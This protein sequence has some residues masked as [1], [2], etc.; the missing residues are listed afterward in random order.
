MQ[1]RN[2]KVQ[3]CMQYITISCVLQ[4]QPSGSTQTLKNYQFSLLFKFAVLVIILVYCKTQLPESK[5]KFILSKYVGDQFFCTKDLL[6]VDPSTTF[7]SQQFHWLGFQLAEAKVK[8]H[9]VN[10][11]MCLCL[12]Q[13][14]KKTV[15]FFIVFGQS[16]PS[17]ISQHFMCFS[18]KFVIEADSFC[19]Q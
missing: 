7:P 3:F 16:P 8:P 14:S 18:F 19:K 9:F 2:E 12:A 11:E 13:L 5:I 10:R 1:F 15:P 4:L 6:L 17:N